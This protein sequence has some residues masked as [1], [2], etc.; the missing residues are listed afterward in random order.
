MTAFDPSNAQRLQQ[1]AATS[2]K[3]L[4]ALQ[5]QWH[6]A[7][8]PSRESDQELKGACRQLDQR[9]HTKHRQGIRCRRPARSSDKIKQVRNRRAV[10]VNASNLY[11]ITSNE[12]VAVVFIKAKSLSA[13]VNVTRTNAPIHPTGAVADR[14]MRMPPSS[15]IHMAIRQSLLFATVQ[16]LESYRQRSRSHPP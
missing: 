10:L 9:S 3:R 11:A 14:S 7:M 1:H 13:R 4:K 12:Q 5:A 15:P 6:L 2:D 8:L 16:S